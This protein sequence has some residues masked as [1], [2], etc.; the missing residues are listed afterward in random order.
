MCE[1][2]GVSA[3]QKIT[4]NSYLDIFYKHSIE[5]HNGWGLALLDDGHISIEKEPQRAVDSVYLKSRLTGRIDTALCMAHIRKAT[6]GCVSFSN[7]HPFM[8]NDGGLLPWVLVHNGTIFSSHILDKYLYEQQGDTDSERILYHIARG[9]AGA[10]GDHARHI[11]IDKMIRS[12]TPGNKI[13]LLLSDG[14]YLYVHKNEPGTLY[15]LT[16][17]GCVLFSTHPLDDE[18]W[19]EFPANRLIVYLE[20]EI[21]YE[22]EPHDNTFI[23]DK[24]KM[25]YQYLDHSML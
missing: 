16:K 24:E 19:K 11:L 21:V 18:P 5:H 13:N 8:V 9:A 4:V 20:G 23:Y 12:L 17:P 7:T 22:G 2:F 15:R 1:L 14:R 3:D 6:V 25:R 10:A